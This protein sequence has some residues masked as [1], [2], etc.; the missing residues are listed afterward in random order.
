MQVDDAIFWIA[1]II[2]PTCLFDARF[3]SSVSLIRPRFGL[4]FVR[5]AMRHPL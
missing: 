5:M 4:G 2:F 1:C 3:F